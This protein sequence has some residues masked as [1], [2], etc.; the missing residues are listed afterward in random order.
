[1]EDRV[2]KTIAGLASFDALANFEA[3]AKRQNRLDEEFATALN[4]RA[5]ELGRALVAERTG[6]DLANLSPAEGKIVF[7]ASE[8]A[9]IKKRQGRNTQRMFNQLANRGLLESAEVSVQKSKPTEGYHSLAEEG[10]AEL[11]YEQIIVDHPKEFSP[12]A[13]WYAKRTLGLP[14]ATPTA[15]AKSTTAVQTRTETLLHWLQGLCEQHG[16][17]FPQYTN[18]DAAA[19]LGMDD[20]RIYGRAYGNIVSRMD[21]ACYKVGLP[22]L[23]LTAET[24]FA[25]AW[26]QQNRV[27]AYPVPA[28]QA[29]AQARRWTEKD[30]SHIL[31]V[32]EGLPGQAYLIWQ[33]E[34]HDRIRDWAYGLNAKKEAPA[35]RSGENGEAKTSH[36]NRS[37]SREEL[38]LALD[39]YLQFRKSPFGKDAA[40]VIELSEFLGT[41]ARGDTEMGDATFR[42]ANGVYMKMMNFR[43]FDQEY[44]SAGKVGLTRG[45]KLEEVIWNEFSEEPQLLAQAISAIRSGHGAPQS[46]EPSYWVFV[47]NPKKWAID[48]FLDRSIEFDSWG[49]RE[50]DATKFAPGQLAIVRVGVDRRNNDE[51][52]GKPPLDAGIYA[53]CEVTSTAYPATGASD[54]FW[55]EGEAPEHSRPT[56]NIRYLHTYLANPLTIERLRGD[57]PAVKPILLDGFQGRSFPISGDDF[58]SVT[59]LLGFDLDDLPPVAEEADTAPAKLTELE[60]QFLKASPEVKERVSRTIERGPVGRAVKIALGFQCQLCAVLGMHPVGFKK[61]NGEPYVEAHHVMPVSSLQVGSLAASN[62]MVLCAN[63]HRQMHYGDVKVHISQQTFDIHIEGAEHKIERISAEFD[64]AAK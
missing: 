33:A 59:S 10:L 53:I 36:R 19:A 26:Q 2:A 62:I 64:K 55:Y 7:A 42:N 18:A 1:M 22:P 23:G 9:A 24:P 45:N 17:Y 52:R 47:C 15:P 48:R 11:S 43:R 39:L 8:Y 34:N 6:L 12:R 58:R 38:I 37:W 40:P 46:E 32:T 63:H 50:S 31:V 21:F 35:L 56:V 60:K 51:R 30:F 28:M 27:W 16:G 20:L 5:I 25:E 13:L 44:T 3:N 57:R 61:R 49:V 14:N 54:E 4:A 41:R 29:A